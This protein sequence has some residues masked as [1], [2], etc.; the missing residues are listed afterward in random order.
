MSWLGKMIADQGKGCRWRYLLMPR[1]LTGKVVGMNKERALG[2]D[3][4]FRQVTQAN[5]QSRKSAEALR[6][7]ISKAILYRLRVA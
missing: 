5:H 3:V 1:Q 7:A 2:G 6:A 4:Q